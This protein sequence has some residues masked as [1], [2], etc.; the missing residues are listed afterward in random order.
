MKFTSTCYQAGCVFPSFQ[1]L[2][3]HSFCCRVQPC[4]L[5]C[6][7]ASDLVD[8]E[9]EEERNGEEGRR[10][11]IWFRHFCSWPS[12]KVHYWR[13]N[14]TAIQTFSWST[15]GCCELDVGSK[16]HSKHKRKDCSWMSGKHICRSEEGFIRQSASHFSV[17][18]R[19][20]IHPYTWAMFWLHGI[21]EW[22][23]GERGEPRRASP[24]DVGG[25]PRELSRRRKGEEQ[26]IQIFKHSTSRGYLYGSWFPV[27]RV[28]WVSRASF[29]PLSLGQ[30]VLL[31]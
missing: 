2:P 4:G 9:E 18:R 20:G 5:P 7:P 27:Q 21:Q 17:Q 12:Y 26:L 30:L 22:G 6:A 8:E 28:Q 10:K 13:L 23:W 25:R 1:A 24:C 15:N 19:S 11:C 31:R 3:E 14:G 29:P 16:T